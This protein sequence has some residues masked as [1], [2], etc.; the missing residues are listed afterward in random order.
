MRV[1]DVER[2]LDPLGSQPASN[3][4]CATFTAWHARRRPS[5]DSQASC[6]ES[7]MLMPTRR[8]S[9]GTFSIQPVRVH[10]YAVLR[11]LL[12]VVVL[13]LF[14]VALSCSGNTDPGANANDTGTNGEGG[15]SGSSTATLGGRGGVDS[16]GMAGTSA[17]TG[18]LS[19]GRSSAGGVANNGTINQ[20]SGGSSAIAGATDAGTTTSGGNRTTAG[21]SGA[22]TTS[23]VACKTPPGA[24]IGPVTC[25]GNGATCTSCP[26]D[27][28]TGYS[29]NGICQSCTTAGNTCTTP[30]C[31]DCCSHQSV[32]GICVDCLSNAQCYCPAACH[33]NKCTKTADGVACSYLNCS[34]CDSG[35]SSNGV[36]VPQCAMDADC[37]AF[38]NCRSG[39]CITQTASA[40]GG[41]S[42]SSNTGGRSAVAGAGGSLGTGGTASAGT[43]ASGGTS[44]AG[45]P[46]N[47]AGGS[48]ASGGSTGTS[49]ATAVA[50]LT[51]VDCPAAKP[52]CDPYSRTCAEC[53]GNW[54]CGGYYP[55]LP[56]FGSLC[57]LGGT[58]CPGPQCPPDAVVAA[59]TCGT[60]LAYCGGPGFCDASRCCATSTVTVGTKQY[61]GNC[62]TH[63][64]C[65]G[66][67][68]C[69]EGTCYTLRT[70]TTNA[71]CGAAPW[72]C[73]NGGCSQCRSDG[74]CS[75][76]FRCDTEIAR[77]RE[78]LSA[79][80]CPRTGDI[81]T[82]GV[83][84][85]P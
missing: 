60:S 12:A 54:H 70:C 66:G 52:W 16:G 19:G 67:S 35:T 33:S 79:A 31:A 14:A 76:G 85:K 17:S 78:C 5:I 13:G 82:G 55:P 23:I 20:R 68:K 8:A 72:T 75:F 3:I 61:C 30:D 29:V 63:D 71:D 18:P 65:S 7:P 39:R 50:C 24:G 44:Q 6:R 9:R 34:D 58:C 1:R 10:S 37:G 4:N 22:S 45:T 49:G 28:C 57:I 2:Q 84:W 69:F 40:T 81:C 80:D 64:D 73:I 43:T 32:A 26:S 77:C 53:L 15:T 74:D 41:T 48:T 42:S 36:C 46:S 51:K 47:S 21:S 59:P 25:K 38:Q 62:Q 56:S 27:C 11:T 83:C